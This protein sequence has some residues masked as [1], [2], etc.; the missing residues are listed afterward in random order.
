LAGM[1]V[2]GRHVWLQH[3]PP[4]RVPECGP[5]LEFILQNFPLRDALGLIFKGSGECAKVDWVFLGLSMPAWTL[6]IF[7]I[8]FGV[9]VGR[10]LA[11]SRWK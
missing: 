2:A 6:L 3:L 8:M 7:T 5:G 10:L 1:A 11:G 4:A 9:C